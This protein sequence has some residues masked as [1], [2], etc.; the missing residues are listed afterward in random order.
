MGVLD[1]RGN[2][3]PEMT[4]GT[5]AKP[6]ILQIATYIFLWSGTVVRVDIGDE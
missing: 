4:L 6:I 2:R 5:Q 3:W 1:C